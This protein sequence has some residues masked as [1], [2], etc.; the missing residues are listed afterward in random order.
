MQIVDRLP[1]ALIIRELYYRAC[2]SVPS[3]FVIPESDGI[4]ADII[5]IVITIIRLLQGLGHQRYG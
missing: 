2:K 4:D 3:A 1:D 5:C